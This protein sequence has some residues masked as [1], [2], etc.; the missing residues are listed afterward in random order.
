MEDIVIALLEANRTLPDRNEIIERFKSDFLAR[1]GRPVPEAPAPQAP[2]AVEAPRFKLEPTPALGQTRIQEAV[3][4]ETTV[5]D[6]AS[7]AAPEPSLWPVKSPE[8]TSDAPHLR[9]A[10]E[11]VVPEPVVPEPAGP[12]APPPEAE[13]GK[14]KKRKRR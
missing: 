12:E 4:A 14:K 3:P 11:P 10:F 8:P 1:Q 9:E 13:G 7:P 5:P 2:A 6:A